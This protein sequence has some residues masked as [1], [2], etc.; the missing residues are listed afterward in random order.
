MIANP[1][2]QKKRLMVYFDVRPN[3][4][5]SNNSF[6]SLADSTNSY[7]A[8]AEKTNVLYTCIAIKFLPLTKNFKSLPV[9][10]RYGGGY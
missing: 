5:N 8:T 1:N 9:F 3:N 6:S 7:V 4:K 2:F 10:V